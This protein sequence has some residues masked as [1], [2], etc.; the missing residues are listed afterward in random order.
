MAR[1]EFKV[2]VREAAWFRSGGT[3][4]AEGEAYGLP[5]GIRCDSSL[6]RGVEYD[7]ILPDGLGGEP[8][9]ENCAAVCLPCHRWKT[10]QEDR[11]RMDKADRILAKRRKTAGRSYRKMQGPGFPKP[12]WHVPNI[13]EAQQDHE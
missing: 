11:P 10:R 12:R 4:E 9:L 5:A 7:H 6:D 8:T 1:R 3:C 13:T 2:A